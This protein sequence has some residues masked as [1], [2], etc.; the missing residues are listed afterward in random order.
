MPDQIAHPPPV[1]HRQLASPG[2]MT[3]RRALFEIELAGHLDYLM[4]VFLR[5]VNGAAQEA[6]SAP[7]VVASA[8]FGRPKKQAEPFSLG[9]VLGFWERLVTGFMSRIRRWFGGGRAEAGDPLVEDY[10]AGLASRMR[11]Q[12]LPGDTYTSVRDVLTEAALSHW[13]RQQ[14]TDH[15]REALS[16]DTG[17]AVRTGEG[18]ID[19]EGNTFATTIDRIARTEATAA[20]NVAILTRLSNS[21]FTGKEWVSHHDA[22]VRKTHA[23]TDGQAVPLTSPFMVGGYAM[24]YPADPVGPMRETASCRCVLVGV[25]L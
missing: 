24:M 12:P 7:V 25:V 6:L 19:S 13:N 16:K 2:S 22:R 8:L 23:A 5:E 3:S 1:E 21:G 11:G 20:F 10:M 15:I 9:R 14:T 18:D 4:G 17:T